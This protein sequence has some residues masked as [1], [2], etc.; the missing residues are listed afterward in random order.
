MIRCRLAFERSWKLGI[1]T[2]QKSKGADKDITN[3]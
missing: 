1:R 3:Y 2:Y